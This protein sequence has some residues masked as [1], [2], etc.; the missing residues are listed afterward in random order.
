MLKMV[1]SEV[2]GPS[3]GNWVS[4]TFCEGGHVQPPHEQFCERRECPEDECSGE[5]V[6]E[7]Q[8]TVTERVIADRMTHTETTAKRTLH[9]TVRAPDTSVDEM[10][11]RRPEIKQALMAR[12]ARGAVL[13]GVHAYTATEKAEE[14]A[15]G[16]DRDTVKFVYEEFDNHGAVLEWD[17]HM[18]GI[19]VMDP[20]S[21]AAGG[22][23]GH[24]ETDIDDE[25]AIR[26]LR[27]LDRV[28]AYDDEEAIEDVAKVV[29]YALRK[30]MWEG[31]AD[32]NR[33]LVTYYG[34][35][36][37]FNLDI[38]EAVPEESRERLVTTIQE[39]TGSIPRGATL[40][41]EEHTPTCEI[42]GCG[43]PVHHVSKA[44][45]MVDLHGQ[46]WT[47]E[48]RRQIMALFEWMMGMAEPPPGMKSPQNEEQFWEALRLIYKKK[49]DE[50]KREIEAR[51]LKRYA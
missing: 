3:C 25:F 32:V 19:V 1:G 33:D 6:R 21:R 14:L 34:D 24:F 26:N 28:E 40:D 22:Q 49:V 29:D 44:K 15:R 47:F 35:L 41:E 42:D 12:G 46:H 16:D 5:Y 17:P 36:H 18:H 30:A 8:A 43:E 39:V 23:G 13:L 2:S 10:Y 20:E 51:G 27:S 11:E 45:S 9:V 38:E 7:N 37:P 31:D 50:A 4:E 48:Q